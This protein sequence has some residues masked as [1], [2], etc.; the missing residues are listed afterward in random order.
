ML[1]ASIV[2]RKLL[3]ERLAFDVCLCYSTVMANFLEHRMFFFLIQP[4][5]F[6]FWCENLV[7]IR[8]VFIKIENLIILDFI[9]F[10]FMIN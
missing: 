1:L 2:V 6:S 4:D 10:L 7:I 3:K 8:N 5:G 9:L